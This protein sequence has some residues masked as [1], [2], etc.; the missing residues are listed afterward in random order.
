MMS[1]H[2]ALASH[3]AA[4]VIISAVGGCASSA[5]TAKGKA[6]E[7]MDRSALDRAYNNSAAVPE[8]GAMFKAWL[9]RSEELRTRHPEHLNLVYGPRPRNR[10]DYFSAGPGTPV[11]VFIHGGFWQMRSKDDFAFLAESFLARGVSVAMVGYPLGPEATMDEIVARRTRGN[12]IPVDGVAQARR[13]PGTSDRVRVV[14]GGHLATMVLDEPL[15]RGGVSISGIYELEPLLKSYVNDKLH[16]DH[17]MAQRNSPILQLPKSSKQLDLFAGSAELP[18][19]R[20]Q[21]A[22]YASA[23]RAAG[24]PMEYAEIPDANHYTV[25]NSMMNSDGTVHRA[26]MAML[27]RP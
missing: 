22:D 3:C 17:V 7:T 8:S 13:R 14:V 21:T 24:L 4:S 1:N 25:L 23:R 9:V 18:E 27:G 6:W 12:P 15:L 10:I 5:P 16:M 11:L 26:I 19:M 20:R 2:R